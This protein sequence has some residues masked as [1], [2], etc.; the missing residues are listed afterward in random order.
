VYVS[1]DLASKI[2]DHCD[3]NDLAASQFFKEAA[4][5][6]LQAFEGESA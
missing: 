6:Q 4:R 2:E 1:P 5:N 3:E